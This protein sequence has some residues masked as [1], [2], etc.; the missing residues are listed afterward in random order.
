MKKL[1]L[2]DN[3]P[4]GRSEPASVAFNHQMYAEMLRDVLL[5]NRAGICVGFFARWGQ[6]KSTIINLLSALVGERAR[7]IV[8]NA[9]QARGDSVRRQM[10]L[11]LLHEIDRKQA[12]ELER[13][14][15]V[16]IPFEMREATVQQE[17]EGKRLAKLLL[18]S[19]ADPLMTCA[20]I[21]AAIFGGLLVWYSGV[22]LFTSATFADKEQHIVS[23]LAFCF[24]AFA[25][26]I[27]RWVQR[28]QDKILAYT[29]PVS[30]SQRLK[31]PEQFSR[32]FRQAVDR[33]MR[34]EKRRLVVVVD[35]LDRCDSATVVEA[36]ASVRHFCHADESENFDC[37]FLIPCDE[38]QMVS[39][40]E[41]DGHK[42][43]AE[44]LRKFFDV[45]V[46]MDE[47]VPESLAAYA[48]QQAKL[49]GVDGRMAR[50]MVDAAAVKEPR[51]VKSLLNAYRLACEIVERSQSQGMLPP[52]D[53]LDRL[54]PTL[55]A[56]VCLQEFAPRIY[57]EVRLD[58]D[59]LGQLENTTD[60]D[61]KPIAARILAGF[62]PISIATAD[63]L[64]TKQDEPSLRGLPVARSLTAA[65]RA[66]HAVDV[67]RLLTEAGDAERDQM[68]G[69]LIQKLRDARSAVRIR[70]LLGYLLECGEKIGWERPGY[71]EFLRDIRRR[72]AHLREVLRLGER[73]RL[74]ADMVAVLPDTERHLFDHIIFE[75]YSGGPDINLVE[76]RYLLRY[77][78]RLSATDTE[79][80]RRAL[81][82]SV[83]TS[84]APKPE[85]IKSL[86]ESLALLPPVAAS[87][88]AVDLA[89]RM[90]RSLSDN[91]VG[92]D[93]HKALL[94]VG[95]RFLGNDQAAA[96]RLLENPLGNLSFFMSPTDITA[97][98]YR[99]HGVFFQLTGALLQISSEPKSATAMVRK[100]LFPWL[101]AQHNTPARQNLVRVFQPAW[102]FL[103]AAERA[104]IGE[105]FASWI[106]DDAQ[107]AK[108]VVTLVDTPRVQSSAWESGRDAI[109]R[110]IFE[111]LVEHCRG[112][113]SLMEGAQHFFRN[114]AAAKWNVAVAAEEL[115]ADKVRRLS[116]GEG[117][118]PD[119]LNDWWQLLQPLCSAELSKVQKEIATGIGKSGS[120]TALLDFALKTVWVASIPAHSAN[121]VAAAII[122]DPQNTL[123]HDGVGKKL[124]TLPGFPEVARALFKQ[125]PGLGANWMRDRPAFLKQLAQWAAQDASIAR[126]F[127]SSVVE[128]LLSQTRVEDALLA[129]ELL[130]GHG[131]L[132]ED[133]KG[134]LVA[135]STKEGID[136]ANRDKIAALVQLPV[137]A[138]E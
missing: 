4:A 59:L 103:E 17:Y 118:R 133:A 60:R 127:Q 14:T 49:I 94:E 32:V 11:R 102:N 114:V 96:A 41:T 97:E 104:R 62:G 24:L 119:R 109:R 45:T 28:R 46:R 84:P 68:I 6:G 79:L 40:I 48:A 128:T 86:A 25:G 47:I 110:A 106:W 82:Q 130:H 132:T 53:Q 34:A 30:D 91:R 18:K 26:Y 66:G 95:L 115:V 12:D 33:F 93:L 122:R 27:T 107:F 19:K 76:E 1:T 85:R 31:Y 74:F 43:S 63:I 138:A 80:F 92:A 100:C 16:E 112:Y 87:G 9:Y 58:P 131:E 67:V 75:N 35:D 117:G 37:Q 21:A 22:V 50:D 90:F 124:V 116:N 137:F 54:E 126:R 113:G 121:E 51:K 64:I 8:F 73:L 3:V 70:I 7:L 125:L 123:A 23:F 20:G 61:G 39:A 88:F 42:Y 13:F 101:T 2:L 77:S 38:E 78:L 55:A 10:L 57:G 65:D 99:T 120:S 71:R 69:W 108:E 81:E 129:L 36:L 15:Q 52:S 56:L 105:V 136:K 44:M 29:Q 5:H 72:K 98:V 89:E 83:M 135:W 111:K 134:A